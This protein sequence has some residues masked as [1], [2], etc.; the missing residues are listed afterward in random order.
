MT[1]CLRSVLPALFP[2]FVVSS[3]IQANRAGRFLAAPL[4]PVARLSGL[5]A[6]DARLILL[7]SWLGGYAVCA[8][9]TGNALR[10]AAALGRRPGGCLCWAAA[11]GRDL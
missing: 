3:L 11:P 10:A 1:L 5:R 9:L 4:F 6:P 7:L 2:F 8:R